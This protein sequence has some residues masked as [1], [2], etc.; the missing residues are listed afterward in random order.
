[1]TGYF[2]FPNQSVC[3][4][5]GERPPAFKSQ[6]MEQLA[7]SIVSAE[8]PFPLDLPPDQT[9][10]LAGAVRC[11]QRKRLVHF[12]ARTIAQHFAAD[13]GDDDC[14]RNLGGD[15]SNAEK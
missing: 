8:I 5:G 3:E 4:D 1:M 10:L 11:Q 13:G 15:V 6:E 14:L 7:E 9:V 12:I 2:P